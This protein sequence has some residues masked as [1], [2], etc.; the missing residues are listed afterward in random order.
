MKHIL[1]REFYARDTVLVAKELLGHVLLHETPE[2]VTAGRIVEAE[3]YIQGDPACHASRGMTPRNRVMFGP[4]GHAY[5]YIIYGM[6]FCFNI[7]TAPEG[8][9][10]AVLIRALEPLEGI[11]LM[12]ER[13]GKERLKELC[14]GPAMLVQSLG[15][16]K[17]NNGDDMVGGKLT[18]CQ[19]EFIGR[20]R[21]IATTRVGVTRGAELPFR[22]YIKDSSYISRK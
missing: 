2:G 3:A 19:G 7:V 21:I 18:V 20:D 15:I 11:P 9:G 5:V 16:S 17:E 4:P 22:F 1:P 13:R 8:V 14:R 6:H 10:E 12:R